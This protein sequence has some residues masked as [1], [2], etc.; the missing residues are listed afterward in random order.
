MLPFRYRN[1]LQPCYWRATK[2]DA[3]PAL[4]PKNWTRS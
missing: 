3:W 4:S 2:G 1:Q